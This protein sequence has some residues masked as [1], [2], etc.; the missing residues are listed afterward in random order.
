MYASAVNVCLKCV[1]C[2]FVYFF[3]HDVYLLQNK[4]H[5]WKLVTLQWDRSNLFPIFN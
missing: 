3:D 2:D 1:I 5:V 4:L